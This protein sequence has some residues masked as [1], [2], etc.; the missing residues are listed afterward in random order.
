MYFYLFGA[1]G[2][3][4]LKDNSGSKYKKFPL[5]KG[6]TVLVIDDFCTQGYSL[7]AARIY[8]EQTKAKVILLSLLKTITKDYEQIANINQ[9]DPFKSNRF[10]FVEK[11]IKHR[12]D[13]YIMEKSAA[14]EISS[15][16]KAYDSWQWELFDRRSNI[17]TI[18]VHEFQYFKMINTN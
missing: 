14:Q 2:Y 9:F 5:K 13:N 7:E 8:I 17:Y 4:S 12:F 3:F 6:K 16:L 15:K 10:T 1:L 18:E 11:I